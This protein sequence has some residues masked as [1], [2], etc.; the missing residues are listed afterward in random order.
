MWRGTNCSALFDFAV[1]EAFRPDV[2]TVVF[3]AF[4]EE[5]LLGEY[6]VDSHRVR[7]YS[8]AD[9]RRAPLQ[10]ESAGTRIALERFRNIVARLVSSQRR[11]FIVLSNPTSPLFDPVFPPEIRLSL[12]LPPALPVGR[13]PHIDAEPFE[14]YVAPLMR[15]L[16]DI[17]AQTGAR[18][19]DPR[20]A[21][22][23]GMICPAAD[24]DGMPLYLDSNH[25]GGSAAR[26]RAS[27]VDDM[28]LGADKQTS[29]S[30]P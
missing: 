25:L 27:F 30:A 9:H 20:T 3:G 28:L 19:V 24:P 22:C 10:L 5:Y 17:A 7:V 16:H 15:R 11:V 18:M 4:W 6:S 13:A 1:E 2:D 21:L 12:H 8:A 23:E 29:A 26:N 14:A